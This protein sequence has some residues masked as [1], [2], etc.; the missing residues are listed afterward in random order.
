MAAV[1]PKMKPAFKVAASS[2]GKIQGRQTNSVWVDDETIT[3]NNPWRKY[4]LKLL[5]KKING[6]WYRPGDW[7]YRRKAFG[8]GGM[9]WIYGDD[10]D[11]M[12]GK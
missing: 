5:P 12:R 11:Y 1:L 6:K 7:V 10:F 8:P 3:P 9:T 2:P 4:R